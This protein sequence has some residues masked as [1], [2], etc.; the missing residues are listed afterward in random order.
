MVRSTTPRYMDGLTTPLQAVFAARLPETMCS[1]TTPSCPPGLA[2]RQ[3][4]WDQ[5]PMA[6]QDPGR[7]A[8]FRLP[9][10]RQLRLFDLRAQEMEWNF[11]I[12]WKSHNI[13]RLL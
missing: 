7:C 2:S 10:N 9:P 1:M 3:M 13:H 5:S 11:S 6:L 12:T 8:I 4:L